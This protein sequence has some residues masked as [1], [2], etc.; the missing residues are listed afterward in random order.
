VTTRIYTYGGEPATRNH[1]VASFQAAKGIRRFV[2][3]TAANLQEA[4]AAAKAG[5]DH[6]SISDHDISIVRTGAPETFVTAA[7]SATDYA[8]R[9]EI[10]R[11]AIS[12]AE[13][14]ADAIY[15]L[16]SLA[17]VEMLASEGLAV[18]GHLGLVPRLST[19]IGGLRIV[20]RKADEALQLAAAVKRLENAGAYA[21]E[22]ECV[23]AEVTAEIRRRSGLMIHSIGS[24]P[25]AD[26]IFLFQEDICGDVDRPPRHARAFAD[27]KSLRAQLRE[28]RLSGLTGF[29][30]AVHAAEYPSEKEYSRMDESEFAAFLDGLEASGA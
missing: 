5:I 4:R 28:E 18:Q 30:D 9:D 8:T 26:V 13:A 27:L 2:Q 1:T 6:L 29:R 3:T 20:G 23:A 11:A 15:T 14:G 21:V 24:G 22:L 17:V 10:L 12:A 19:R 25:D 16:R 7:L